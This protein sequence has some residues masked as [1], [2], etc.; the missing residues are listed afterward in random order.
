MPHPPRLHLQI[1]FFARTC[2]ALFALLQLPHAAAAQTVGDE[3]FERRVRPLLANQC[4]R[5]HGPEKQ[6]GELRLDSRV[7]M[8]TGGERGP[9]VVPGAPERSLLLSAIRREGDL[10]MPPD[11]TI[12]PDDAA[13]VS[14]WISQGAVWPETAT[15]RAPA[16]TP[17]WAFQPVQEPRVPDVAGVHSPIDAFVRSRLD[18]VGLAVSPP[19]DRRTLIRRATFDLTGLPPTPSE[20]DAFLQNTQPGAWPRLIDRLL[21]SKHYGEKWARH[22]LDVARYSDSK[23]YVYAR[24]ERFWV[25]AWAYRDW[26]IRALNSDMPYDR[27]LLLQIAADQAEGAQKTDLAAMGFLTIG[28]RFL[29]VTHDIIDDRIDVVTRGTMGL[30]V[31]CAR[32]HDHKYDPIPTEDYYSLYGVF[33][34]SIERLVPLSEPTDDPESKFS[35]G[36]KERQS[37]LA[38]TLATRRREA[39]DRV[40]SR[41]GDYLAAQLELENYPE[42][43]F[44]QILLVDDIKPAFVRRWRDFLAEAARRHDTVFSAWRMFRA[45]PHA[46]FKDVAADVCRRLAGSS[47]EL[48]HP[49]VAAAF[50]RPPADMAEVAQRYGELFAEVIADQDPDPLLRAI[51]FGD[52]APCEVPNEPIV[53]TELFFPTGQ[54]EELWKLQGE[55]DRWLLQ[56]AEAPAYALILADRDLKVQ[57]R[58]LLRGNPATPGDTVPRRFP[59]AATGNRQLSAFSNGSGRLEL[60]K[61]ITDPQNPLTARVAVNRVWMHHFGSGLVPTPSDFGT[62]A[63]S[64]SHPGLLNYLAIRFQQSGWSL[65]AL[66]REIMLSDTYRQSSRAAGHR[67]LSVDPGNRLLWRMSP[68]RLQF[69]E[70]RDALLAVAGELDT[71]AGGR[72]G[73]LFESP[74]RT[75]YARVDRQFFPQLLRAFDVANPDLHIGQRSTTTVPQQALFL[76]N[77]PFPLARA[78]AVSAAATETDPS[79]RVRS[80]YRRVLQREPDADETADALALVSAARRPPTR[81]RV[82]AEWQYGFGHVDEQTGRVDAFEKLPW[83]GSGE[84]R[85]GPDWPDAKLG[86][87]QLTARGGHAGN[88]R[89]HAAIRRW[90]APQNMTVTVTSEITHPVPN[91]D[92]VRAFLVSSRHGVLKQADVHNRS[93]KFEAASLTVAAGETIDFV[94]DLQSNLNHEEFDWPVKIQ[95]VGATGEPQPAAWDSIR[96]FGGTPTQTADPWTQLAQVLMASNEFLFVD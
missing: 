23:G 11:D 14:E 42:Q 18:E 49:R 86:W 87:V 71:T 31:A 34:N 46:D 47:S 91:G 6:S 20:V 1:R 40:R 5:C 90:V 29:G 67:G 13:A 37:K 80:I 38:N 53:N 79:D 25:H 82:V 30:T 10:E 75:I 26:V 65:K 63:Q 45:I 21:D 76:L 44:D 73:D 12:S 72:P 96:D 74:R 88:D 48:V 64:P 69:E 22:W 56:S 2:A 43:G 16:E 27:F 39:A 7:A 32:C 35:R 78:Q 62:R 59:R 85:G 89:R 54:C 68:R 4:I 58:V 50:R 77:H 19:A 36:L 8:L 83:F 17:H 51:L 84:W 81:S 24:E 61:A 57:S 15:I 95:S 41:I 66:H 93:E 3:L 28:R 9:A 55:V 60:A 33:R 92:G 52:Q 94:V 70:L